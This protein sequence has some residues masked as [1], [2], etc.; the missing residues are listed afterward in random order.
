MIPQFE[1][2]LGSRFEILYY[3]LLVPGSERC[4]GPAAAEHRHLAV[5]GAA[6]AGPVAVHALLGYGGRVWWPVRAGRVAKASFASTER[7]YA[8]VVPGRYKLGDRICGVPWVRSAV[9]ATG[10]SVRSTYGHR[11]GI[12]A[13]DDV[14]ERHRGGKG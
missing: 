12:R 5:H 14:R 1:F 11:G 3:E 2:V 7:G 13:W 9:C 6:A 10:A 8:G 4:R